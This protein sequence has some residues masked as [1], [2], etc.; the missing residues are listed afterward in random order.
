MKNLTEKQNLETEVQFLKEEIET[1]KIQL[2][3][4]KTQGRT[5]EEIDLIT[6]LENELSEANSKL[7]EV[8]QEIAHKE[9]VVEELEGLNFLIKNFLATVNK[10]RE[11]EN[12]L[13]QDLDRNKKLLTT[14]KE[15]STKGRFYGIS[16]YRILEQTA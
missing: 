14:E 4:Q 10:L 7:I 11:R 8:G 3:K 2:G 15:N 9:I 12:K 1:L 16:M 5:E 6:Q 13:K